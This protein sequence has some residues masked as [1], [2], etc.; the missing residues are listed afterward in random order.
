M[1]F[2]IELN[3]SMYSKF[4]YLFDRNA[5]VRGYSRS[6]NYHTRATSALLL[7][8]FN[9]PRPE[10]V[11]RLLQLLRDRENIVRMRASQALSFCFT[12]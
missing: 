3:I 12:L 7:G 4:Y 5:V 8:L 1:Y 2:L 6:E 9:S 10:D 11:Q